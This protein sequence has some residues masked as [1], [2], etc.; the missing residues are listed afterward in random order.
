MI[1][2]ENFVSIATIALVTVA[3]FVSSGSNADA[4][5]T[6]IQGVSVNPHDHVDTSLPDFDGDG[7]VGFGDFLLFAENFGL[8]HGDA[9]YDARYDLNGDWEVGFSDFV[10]FSRNFGRDASSLKLQPWD[11]SKIVPI[12]TVRSEPT[13]RRVFMRTEFDNGELA[14]LEMKFI[15]V[16]D[17]F[18]PPMP[19]YM[20]E[21]SDSVLVS[22]GGIARGMSGSPIFTVQGVWGAIAFGFNGQDSP[23]YYFFA[24]PIEWVIGKKGTVPLA[25]RA[26]AWGDNRI[27]PLDVPLLSTGLNGLQLPP[28]GSPSP[29]SGAVSAGLTTQ[30]QTSYAPGRPLAV[31]FL[32]GELTLGAFGT[33]SFV[34][35]DRIYGFGHSM[36]DAGPVSLPIIEAVVLGEISNLSAPFKFVTLNPTVRGTLTEDRIPGVRGVLDEG[37]DLVSIR[38]A[39][40]FP[41]GAVVELAHAMPAVI[42]SPYTAID[43]VA[44]AFFTPLSNRVEQDPDHSIRVSFDVSFDAVDSSLTRSRLFASP[45]GHLASLVWNAGSDLFDTLADLMTRDDYPLQVTDAGVRVEVISEARFAKVMEVSADTV[46]TPGDTLAVS[47]SLRV[48][49]RSDREIE[50]ALSVPDT[51]QTGVYRLEA[52]SVATL[53]DDARGG[54]GPSPVSG[55]F[56]PPDGF[57]DDETLQEVFARV[58][59][60]DENVLLKVR[61]AFVSPLEDNADSTA[62][63][64]GGL[65]G[66]LT[67]GLG[68]EIPP[69]GPTATVSAQRDVGLFLEGSSDAPVKVVAP[70]GP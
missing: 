65:A 25:K 43:L 26:A 21:A 7:T 33:I 41:N 16:V 44:N 51:F 3:V 63:P 68:G 36:N 19:V 58:N 50:F 14:D 9:G 22:L 56:G 67:G 59:R 12:D 69:P 31:G 61:L 24:T 29:L 53:G 46:V 1:S 10:I 34:D 38:S 47:A 32:L 64:P 28:E 17:D 6:T 60:E 11:L 57:G 4:D 54:E 23:P 37:P 35:G 15:A 42:P 70:A 39:Y 2:R 40:A 62:L 27:V 5:G 66:V 8:S 30:R 13:G 52:G 55:F 20:V 45:E 18:L 49:R 48:G